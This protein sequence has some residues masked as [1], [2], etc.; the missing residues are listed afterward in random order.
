MDQES[1]NKKIRRKA[2]EEAKSQQ[3]E[4]VP[5]FSKD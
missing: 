3:H 5:E 2:F 1:H 4:E